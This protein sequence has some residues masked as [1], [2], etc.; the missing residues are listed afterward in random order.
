MPF[1][2]RHPL[3]EHPVP[4]RNS[5][6][7]TIGLPAPDGAGPRRGFHVP[8]TRDTTGEDALLNPEASGVHTS[9]KE[10]PDAACRL[11]QQP[12]PTTLVTDPSPRALFDEASSKSSLTF[13]RPVFPS[14]GCSPRRNRGPWASTLSFAPHRARP[15]NARQG[16]DRSRTLT[17]NYAPGITG[18]QTASSLAMRDSVSHPLEKSHT[19]LA[20]PRQDRPGEPAVISYLAAGGTFGSEGPDRPSG[21]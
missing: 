20:S 19:H 9:D 12:G 4:P 10:E 16:G 3:L 11:Y 13:T 18:L 17:E 21:G 15:G 7:L 5:A 14:P 1:G 8:R 2:H 6:P